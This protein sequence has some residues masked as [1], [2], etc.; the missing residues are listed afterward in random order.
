MPPQN[1][2]D[3]EKYIIRVADSPEIYIENRTAR[4]SFTVNRDEPYS[5]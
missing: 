4:F 5:D 1:P 2:E 3:V